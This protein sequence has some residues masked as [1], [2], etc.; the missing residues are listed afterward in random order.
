MH[1]E[2]DLGP[3]SQVMAGGSG[4]VQVIVAGLATTCGK[5]ALRMISCTLQAASLGAMDPVMGENLAMES[6]DLLCTDITW[7]GS[8]CCEER[9]DCRVGQRGKEKFQE[10]R[11]NIGSGDP[12][13]KSS[14]S[15][16]VG[17][18]Q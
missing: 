9:W 7:T 14:V 1:A 15:V 5:G 16:Q 12:S 11:G 4:R 18:V 17:K 8:S 3:S 13:W 6:Q 10:R 2:S